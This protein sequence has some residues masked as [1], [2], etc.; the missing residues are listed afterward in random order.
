VRAHVHDVV[1]HSYE[2][3][4]IDDQRHVASVSG[5]RI[6]SRIDSRTPG[7]GLVSLQSAVVR[8]RS[9]K[10]LG[11]GRNAADDV[12]VHSVNKSACWRRDSYQAVSRAETSEMVRIIQ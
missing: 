8:E 12:A 6:V 2:A 4:L 3:P 11:W 9:Q 7:L 10:R 5:Q 1:G